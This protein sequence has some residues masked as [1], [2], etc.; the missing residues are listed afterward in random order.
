MTID[1][2]ALSST[3]NKYNLYYTFQIAPF[4]Q[5][6]LAPTTAQQRLYN[7]VSPSAGKHPKHNTQ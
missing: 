3:I 5:H 4:K 1:H 2:S 6:T 7:A